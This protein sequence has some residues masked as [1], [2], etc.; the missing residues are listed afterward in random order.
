MRDSVIFL[1]AYQTTK[2]TK[3]RNPF[4]RKSNMVDLLKK[5]H[6]SYML[7]KNKIVSPECALSLNSEYDDISQIS[8]FSFEPINKKESDCDFREIINSTGACVRLLHAHSLLTDSRYFKMEQMWG[9]HPFIVYIDDDAFQIDPMAFTINSSIIIAYEMINL[10]T[11]IP[12]NRDDTSSKMRNW[13]LRRIK[14]YQYFEDESIT[15]SS[16]TISELIYRNLCDFYSELVRKKFV[17]NDYWY[18]YDTLVLSDEIENIEEYFC[19]L[20]GV[21]KLPSPLENISTTH[22]YE[23]YFQDGAS[24]VTKYDHDDIETPLYNAIVFESLKL[25]VYLFQIINEQDTVDLNSVMRNDLYLEN[26]FFAPN[27]PIETNNLLRCIRNSQA[28]QHRREAI[29]LK[30]SYMT[31]ENEAKRNRNTILL[32]VLLYIASLLGAIST[33]DAL[34]SRLNIP[35]EFSLIIVVL[36]FGFFGIIWGFIEYRHN[37][38]F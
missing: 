34:E 11:G 17:P 32:N 38:R 20:L 33:L 5:H 16:C 10:K 8:S 18:V 23:F 9:L 14:G 25:Y 15:D 21:T 19:G 35:F 6:I 31:T 30:I 7:H 13:N 1:S 3:S 2:F 27:V 12:L 36:F 4:H 26:L 22:N 37:K 28:F 24:V 29:K